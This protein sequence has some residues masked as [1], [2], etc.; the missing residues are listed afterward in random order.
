[1]NIKKLI[2]EEIDAFDWAKDI[3]T[4]SETIIDTHKSSMSSRDILFLLH[5]LGYK[6]NTDHPIVDSKGNSLMGT[7]RYIL[8]GPLHIDD[9]GMDVPHM[10]IMHEPGI[11]YTVNGQDPNKFIVTL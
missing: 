3:P 7:Y 5:D 1:M 2:R 4:Y 6:W 11:D 10:T 8:V 9:Y